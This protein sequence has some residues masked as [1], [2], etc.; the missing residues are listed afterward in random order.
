[1]ERKNL[2]SNLTTRLTAIFA[3]AAL[4][5]AGGLAV[6]DVAVASPEGDLTNADERIGRADP[7]PLILDN[8]PEASED[9][10]VAVALAAKDIAGS[11]AK[12]GKCPASWE[13]D[14]VRL[15]N[16]ERKKAGAKEVRVA[17]GGAAASA[18]EW[19]QILAQRNMLVHSSQDWRESRVPTNVLAGGENVAWNFSS[20][21]SVVNGWMNSDEHKAN[22]LNPAWDQLAVGCYVDASGAPFW[23]QIFFEDEDLWGTS[24]GVTITGGDLYNLKVGQELTA[25]PGEGYTYSQP[26]WARV[27]PG[28]EEFLVEEGWQYTVAAEDLEPGV[29]LR[30]TAWY[31]SEAEEEDGEGPESEDGENGTREIEEEVW[32]LG[33]IDLPG[34]PLPAEAPFVW[35]TKRHW[36]QNRYDTS[37]EIVKAT[38]KKNK[39]VFVATGAA[40][41]DALSAGAAAGKT[42]GTLAL[43]R[44]NGMDAKMLAEVKSLNPPE[45]YVMGGSGAVSDTVVAQLKTIT[46]NVDRVG[47]KNRYETSRNIATQFFPDPVELYVATGANFPDAL[48]ASA[49]AGGKG[50]PV[51]LVNGKASS[52]DRETRSAL[53]LLAAENITIAGGTG[54][55]SSGVEKSL[56]SL[57]YSVDRKFGETRYQTAVALNAGL[58]SKDG[59]WLVSGLDFPDAVGAAAAAANA[60]VPM[61]LSKPTCIDSSTKAAL[62]KMTNLKNIDLAGGTGVLKTSVTQFADCVP[63]RPW[64]E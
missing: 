6:A 28:G 7:S 34:Q 48:A 60:K 54:A 43:T 47:G 63:G 2:R 61:Y 42:G 27:E 62:R 59:A 14:V 39:P 35:K 44:R 40:Y 41:P 56:K 30:F 53:A 1:M 23:A 36:G 20:P 55:V 18:R 52:L 58:D 38:G 64:M 10:E 17:T 13:A 26:E 19:A 33:F 29:H 9:T 21:N 31:K 22:I 25:A 50:V 51:L 32:E 45:I 5:S 8:S 11:A 15:S 16:A 57:G 37:L 49:V 46:P 12:V 24:G 4:L 3:T